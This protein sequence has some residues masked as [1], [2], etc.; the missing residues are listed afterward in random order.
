LS[1]DQQFFD[2]ITVAGGHKLVTLRD[3]AAYIT[4]LPKEEQEAPQWQLA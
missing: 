4:A 2:P 1:W 3:A